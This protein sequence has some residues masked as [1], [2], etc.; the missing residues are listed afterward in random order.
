MLDEKL[1]SVFA[2]TWGVHCIWM[3]LKGP[4][5]YLLVDLQKMEAKALATVEYRHTAILSDPRAFEE[6]PADAVEVGIRAAEVLRVPY[7]LAIQWPDQAGWYKFEPGEKL[8][9]KEA[10]FQRRCVEIPT[11]SFKPFLK[12]GPTLP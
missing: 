10:E 8:K 7:V 9:I 5:D 12:K 1:R 3:P 11:S 4:A 2:E 6:I